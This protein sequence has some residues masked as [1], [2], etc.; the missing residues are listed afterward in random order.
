QVQ[1]VFFSYDGENDVL[2][3]INFKVDP[4]DTLAVVGSTGSGKTTLINILTR[5]Y[6]INRG[7][8]RI[9]DVN[10]KDYQLDTL[11]QHIGVVLQD[12]FLFTGTIL[13]NIRMMDESIDRE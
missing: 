12:V 7:A 6:E 11:R 5:F 1:N 10:I 8:I 2:R 3:D 4:G 9:D 13:N